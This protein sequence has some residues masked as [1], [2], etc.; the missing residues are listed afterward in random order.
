MKLVVK[1]GGAAAEGHSRR[2]LAKQIAKLCRNGAQVVLVHGGGKILTETL[3]R[4]GIATRF[5]NGLRVT[6]GEARDVALMVLAGLINKQW[7]SALQLEGQPALGLC[8][9]DGK[10][11]VARKLVVG[12][13]GRARNL[14][15][16]G[17]PSKVRT[18]PI[19][20]AWKQGMVPV[21]ASL[22]LGPKGDYLN[23]N[24]DDLAASVATHL[25][26]DRLMYLTEAG[27]VWDAERRLLPQVKAREIPSL[28]RRGIV[29]DGMIPKLL[30]CRRVLADGVSEVDILPAEIP[31]GLGA[32]LS[33]RAAAGTRILRDRV[34]E[35]PR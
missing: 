6:D 21:L 24:A 2:N 3:S 15:F 33:G 7:V 26:A 34:Q 35:L 16:V 14:G 12:R 17:R 23:V 25:S 19:E 28:I 31:A 20:M 32:F 8:G 29:R 1:V 5:E 27:G 4:M 10:L 30:S 9:G 13:G 11:V 18:Q 22:A